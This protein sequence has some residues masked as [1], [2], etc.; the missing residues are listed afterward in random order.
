MDN[1]PDTPDSID[2]MFDSLIAANYPAGT[3]LDDALVGHEE[4][5]QTEE[6]ASSG[7]VFDYDAV[8]D[9]DT[10]PAGRPAVAVEQRGRGRMRRAAK[11]LVV[12]SFKTVTK[13]VSAAV[14][15]PL[16]AL[17]II[18]AAGPVAS[19]SAEVIMGSLTGATV[20]IGAVAAVLISSYLKVAT[21]D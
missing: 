5:H 3:A 14:R 6:S 1:A 17:V 20:V 16:R 19:L 18:V 12:G 11:S 10:V 15:H 13:L 8:A 9:D 4:V 7:E 21:D 2:E